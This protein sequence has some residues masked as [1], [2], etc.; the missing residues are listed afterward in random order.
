MQVTNKWK[1]PAIDEDNVHVYGV[2]NSAWVVRV[3]PFTQSDPLALVTSILNPVLSIMNPEFR[4]VPQ[5]TPFRQ[6]ALYSM[7][8][9]PSYVL[10][11]IF[12]YPF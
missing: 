11:S 6:L 9:E 1:S 10:E 7:D 12:A 8:D 5:R 4:R 2:D 3:I